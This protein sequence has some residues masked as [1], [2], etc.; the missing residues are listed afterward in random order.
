MRIGDSGAAPRISGPRAQR[1]VAQVIE[2]ELVAR[3]EEQLS[4]SAEIITW[5]G[6][7][8][9]DV[10]FSGL[11]PHELSRKHESERRLANIERHLPEDRQLRGHEEH[12]RIDR[13]LLSVLLGRQTL[14][15]QP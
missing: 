7:V 8:V 5:R 11:E 9:F 4:T 14:V 15:A 3:K 1:L 13:Q 12:F 10:E 2:P 6:N